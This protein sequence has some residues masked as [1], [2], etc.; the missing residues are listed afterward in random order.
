MHRWGPKGFAI[1]VAK[2]GLRPR[3]IFHTA[4]EPQTDRI[5]GGRFV[6]RELVPPERLVF[7]VSFSDEAGNVT[8]TR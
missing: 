1:L 4:C 5:C 3:G 6:Y 2:V 7:I 8:R